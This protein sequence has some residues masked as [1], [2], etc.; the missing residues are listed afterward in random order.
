MDYVLS[1]IRKEKVEHYQT[2]RRHKDGH[3]VDVSLTVSPI[4]GAD[5]EVTGASKIARDVTGQKRDRMRRAACSP[6]SSTR[7]TTPS[8]ARIPTA[9]SRPATPA[10]CGSSAIRP[11]RRSAATYR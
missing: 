7:P 6:P 3:M 8:S 11:T 5:G 2:Q 10:P 1:Q 4:L 9:R